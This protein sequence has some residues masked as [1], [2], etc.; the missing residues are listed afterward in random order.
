MGSKDQTHR[1]IT[2]C[3]SEH[4]NKKMELEVTAE[5]ELGAV[6]GYANDAKRHYHGIKHPHTEL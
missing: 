1:D 3:L 2:C 6:T 4:I 5:L